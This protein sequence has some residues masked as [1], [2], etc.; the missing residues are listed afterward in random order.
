[1]LNAAEIAVLRQ[2]ASEYAQAASLGGQG[3]RRQRWLNLNHLRG[4]RPLVL[5][6]QIPWEE[7]DV[8]GSLDCQVRDPYWRGVET[9][10]RQTLY[11]WRHMPA[12]MVLDPYIC[13]P[14][15]ICSSASTSL[16]PP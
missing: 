10:L 7:M 1:M 9:N 2:L 12:D 11:K 16:A 3:E 13:L 5:I 8:D 15:P 6:D 4:E 14:R